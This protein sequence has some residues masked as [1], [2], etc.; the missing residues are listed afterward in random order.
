MNLPMT[1]YFYPEESKDFPKSQ[2]RKDAKQASPAPSK[3]AMQ[4]VLGYG[5]ALSIITTDSLGKMK[6]L[7][8]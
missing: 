8:N 1:N 5:A 3:F 2:K 6:I 4:F 7:M